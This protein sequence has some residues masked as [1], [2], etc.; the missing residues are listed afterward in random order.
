MRKDEELNVDRLKGNPE[1]AD[2]RETLSN[3]QEQ[4]A[5]ANLEEQILTKR[6]GAVLKYCPSLYSKNMP[7]SFARSLG[8][9]AGS[10]NLNPV[11]IPWII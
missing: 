2:L 9:I 11:S 4:T 5:R 8:E 6:R 7:F 3:N 1:R 10:L